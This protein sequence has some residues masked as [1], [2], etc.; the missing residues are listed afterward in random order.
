MSDPDLTVSAM[1]SCGIVAREIEVSLSE[2]IGRLCS[3]SAHGGRQGAALA[4]AYSFRILR[5]RVKPGR[6]AKAAHEKA[7]LERKGHREDKDAP[8]AL[9][10]ELFEEEETPIKLWHGG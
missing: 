9:A 1:A 2:A 6:L 10:D 7:G 4:R 3:T 5:N 8:H